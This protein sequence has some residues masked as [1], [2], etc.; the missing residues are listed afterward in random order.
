MAN[1]LL[2]LESFPKRTRP[3][4][5]LLQIEIREEVMNHFHS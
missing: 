4:S 2:I 3:S 5:S 1:G